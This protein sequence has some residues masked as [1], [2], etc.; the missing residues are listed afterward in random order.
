MFFEPETGIPLPAGT[1]VQT[2]AVPS[3]DD[4]QDPAVLDGLQAP[5]P[6]L[7]IGPEE[8]VGETDGV[9]GVLRSEERRVGKECRSRWGADHWNKKNSGDRRGSLRRGDRR[10][11]QR[12]SKSMGTT[13]MRST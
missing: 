11:K 9:V 3:Q 2:C 6:V 5:L 12:C 4:L 13:A 8:L 10:T 1:G 7:D